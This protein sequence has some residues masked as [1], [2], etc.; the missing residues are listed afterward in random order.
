MGAKLDVKINNMMAY[1]NM[2]TILQI[3]LLVMSGIAW[4]ILVSRIKSPY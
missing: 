3:I 2:V 1:N 4:I